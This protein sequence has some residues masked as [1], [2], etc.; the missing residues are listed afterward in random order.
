M[1]RRSL[2]SIVRWITIALSRISGS[3]ARAWQFDLCDGSYAEVGRF[4]T[5]GERVFASPSADDWVLALDDAS[6]NLSALGSMPLRAAG[7]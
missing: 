2:V 1:R 5:Q 4:P 3:E 6:R 7:E